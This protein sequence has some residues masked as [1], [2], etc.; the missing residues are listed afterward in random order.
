VTASKQTVCPA[1]EPVTTSST[2]NTPGLQLA[3]K[4]S[5][6]DSPG[7]NASFRELI[8]IPTKLKSLS[9]QSG[10]KRKVWHA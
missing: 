9:N 3:I 8:P 2:I 10:R 7:Q 4:E 1:L 6:H 5:E